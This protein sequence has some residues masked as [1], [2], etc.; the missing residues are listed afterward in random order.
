MQILIYYIYR[1]TMLG[2]ETDKSWLLRVQL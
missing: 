1:L 2:A